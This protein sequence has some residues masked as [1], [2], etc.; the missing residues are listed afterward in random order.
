MSSDSG[1]TMR[2]LT[3]YSAGALEMGVSV[4]VGLA[5]GY[6][7]DNWF[8]TTPWMSLFWLACGTVAGFRS[9]YRMAKKLEREE[10]E[11][12]QGGTDADA[13]TRDDDRSS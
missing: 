8:G 11:G 3:K 5:I 9:L 2:A 13:D 6:S 7:L 12:E 10:S 1:D 4:V